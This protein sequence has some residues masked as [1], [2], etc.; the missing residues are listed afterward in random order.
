M[1]VPKEYNR[2]YTP[3]SFHFQAI[4][5]VL[6][7][8]GLATHPALSGHGLIITV[9]YSTAWLDFFSHPELF[10]GKGYPDLATR[11]FVKT[12]SDNMPER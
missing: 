2:V 9:I 7:T 6:R 12:F 5:H 3:S 11:Q 10:Q 8:A 1:F 4:F